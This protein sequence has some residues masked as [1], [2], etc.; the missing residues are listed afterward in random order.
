V[1]A[2][3]TDGGGFTNL[4]SF[5]GTLLSLF[6]NTDG[7]VPE[8]CLILSGSTLYGTAAS[9]GS[10]GRGTVFRLYTNGT[11]FAVL[12]NFAGTYTGGNDG[13]QPTAGLVLSDVTLYGTSRA[14]GSSGAGTVFSLSLG[15]VLT[16]TRLGTNVILTWPTN[17]TGFTLQCTTDLLPL[18]AWAT[19]P[20]DPVVVNGQNAVT[21][22][23]AG[24]RKFYRLS[25]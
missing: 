16:I 22:A 7:A 15:P 1:F 24:P 18:S 2:V 9:A 14:G 21:N 8:A 5:V 13:G 11:S 6:T 19:N 10:S 4:H 20:P 17:P 25:Q 12:H 23:T 3:N